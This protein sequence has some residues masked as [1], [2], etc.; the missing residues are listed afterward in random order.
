M[1]ALRNLK[2]LTKLL[3][4]PGVVVTVLVLVALYSSYGFKKQSDSIQDITGHKLV[5]L[6]IANR[7]ATDMYGVQSAAYKILG[8]YTAEVPEARI[9]ASYDEQHAVIN[10]VAAQLKEMAASS[11]EA[12]V[13]GKLAADAAKTVEEY[14]KGLTEMMD[15]AGADV[16]TATMYMATLETSYEKLRTDLSKLIAEE[17]AQVN[18]TAEAVAASA[19]RTMAILLVVA[20]IAAVFSTFFTVA[21][22]RIVSG[23]IS[24]VKGA[25]EALAEGDLGVTINN[26][27]KDEVGILARAMAKMVD[28]LRQVIG[29]LKFEVTELKSGSQTLSTL[30]AEVSTATISAAEKGTSVAAATEEAS[31]MISTIANAV[32]LSSTNINAIAAAIEEM[33]ATVNDVAHSAAKAREMADGAAVDADKVATGVSELSIASGEIGRVTDTITDI[34]EQTKLLALNATI[35]AARAGEAGKGFAVVAA[36]IKELARQ[37][38]VATTE[39]GEKV[40]KIQSSTDR[41]VEGI[42]NIVQSIRRMKDAMTSIAAAI[43]QQSATTREIAK[44][45]SETSGGLTE[46]NRNTSQ[47]TL[48]TNQISADI[49]QVSDIMLNLSRSVSGLE[50]SADGLKKMAEEMDVMA[51]WFKI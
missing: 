21:L 38:N 49:S 47:M 8:W 16:N 3:L 32:S 25:A 12:S 50:D 13:E 19:K 18:A 37:T 4:V 28:T 15:L 35:E 45:V 11:G 29:K 36:E 27:A 14:G 48:A 46:V 7:S 5:E 10:R 26:A 44:N 23:S 40:A 24:G 39:I 43:E 33:S 22:A 6:D 42:T 1:Q 17:K 9:R 30:A 31:V 41:T 2:I 34:S 20:V 51:G